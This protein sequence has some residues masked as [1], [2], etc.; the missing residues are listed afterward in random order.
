MSD[1]AALASMVSTYYA[2]IIQLL[3]PIVELIN[4]E[5]FYQI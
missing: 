1:G 2:N 3:G 4:A 5:V